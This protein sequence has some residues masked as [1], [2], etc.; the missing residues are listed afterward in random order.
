MGFYLGDEIIMRRIEFK[1]SNKLHVKLKMALYK[2]IFK[3]LTR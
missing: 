1:I 3:L 2:V